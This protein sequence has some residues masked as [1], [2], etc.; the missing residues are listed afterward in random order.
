MS[1]KDENELRRM[2][3][4]ALQHDGP[5]ALRYPR[6]NGVGVDLEQ[7]IEPLVL[8]QAEVLRSGDEVLFVAFGPVVQHALSAAKQLLSEHGISCSVINARFAKPLD[9]ELLAREIPRHRLVCTVEDHALQGGFGSAVVEFV[10]QNGL[11]A[12]LCVKCFGVSDEFVPHASQT[13]QYAALGYDAKTLCS[14]VAANYAAPRV[15]AAG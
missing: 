11:G 14:W 3:L 4:T 15:A 13:E 2:L 12:N 1:P 9:G 6:G 10:N 7:H 5:C 8:G